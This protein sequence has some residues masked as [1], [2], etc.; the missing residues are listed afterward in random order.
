MK[1]TWTSPEL[2]EYGPLGDVTLGQH[3]SLPDF[4]VNGQVFAN[5]NCDPTESGAGNS[6]NSN[7][8]ICGS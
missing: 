1:K 6:G 5:D 2:I 7:P 8:F 3:G 4:N